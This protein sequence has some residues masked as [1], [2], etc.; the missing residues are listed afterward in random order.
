MG[1]AKQFGLIALAVALVLGFL[2]L[3]PQSW[4]YALDFTSLPGDDAALLTWLQAQPGVENAQVRR[5][6]Q[7]VTVAFEVG[8]AAPPDVLAQARAL[9]YTGLKRSG[10]KRTVGLWSAF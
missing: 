7:T 1:R 3:R 8:A 4:T 9:G 10:L 6:G 5:A 2:A